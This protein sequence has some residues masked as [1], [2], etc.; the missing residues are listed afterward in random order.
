MNLEGILLYVKIV[1]LG[2]QDAFSVEKT[3][4]SRV[5]RVIPSTSQTGVC[6]Y[7]GQGNQRDFRCL[8]ALVSICIAGRMLWGKMRYEVDEA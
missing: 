5:Q 7:A 4:F 3:K 8:L 2:P 1:D 6:S